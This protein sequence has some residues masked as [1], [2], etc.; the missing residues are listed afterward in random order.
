MKKSV[1]LLTIGGLLI[2]VLVWGIFLI[3]S[4]E[5]EKEED[6]KPEETKIE[7]VFLEINPQLALKV[8]ETNEVNKVIYLNEEALVAYDE[9]DFLGEN[10]NNVVE[11]IINDAIDLGYIDEFSAE[12][13]ITIAST[14]EDLQTPIENVVAQTIQNR[15]V[16]GE[17]AIEEV[18]TWRENLW[19]ILE[20]EMSEETI[21]ELLLL[22]EQRRDHLQERVR[23]RY[24]TENISEIREELREEMQQIREFVADS[25]EDYRLMTRQER[26]ELIAEKGEKIKEMIDEKILEIE[27]EKSFSFQWMRQQRNGEDIEKLQTRRAEIIAE[28]ER[29]LE[30]RLAEIEEELTTDEIKAMEREIRR[31]LIIDNNDLQRPELPSEIHRRGRINDDDENDEE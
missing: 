23:A 7:I 27:I 9:Q 21:E 1:L 18:N 13:L 8:D 14:S 20:E 31:E 15:M 22:I 5:E 2:A 11:I 26:A 30:K 19:A 4:V 25:I 29:I 24:E 10:L 3:L 16:F 6:K 28:T 17:T 12:N